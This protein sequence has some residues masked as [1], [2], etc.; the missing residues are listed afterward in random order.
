MPKFAAALGVT[1][2]RQQR[3]NDLLAVGLGTGSAQVADI[4]AM[5][6]VRRLPSNAHA[7]PLTDLCFDHRLHYIF[8]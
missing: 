7:R 8:N 1:H 4:D 5:R 2:L 3:V 6:L